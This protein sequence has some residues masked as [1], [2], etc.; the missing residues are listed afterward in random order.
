MNRNGG[1]AEYVVKCLFLIVFNVIFYMT[2]GIQN[3]LSV[4]IAYGFIH[5]AYLSVLLTP[6]FIPAGENRAVFGM[7]LFVISMAY[8]VIT[9]LMGI[10]V[11]LTRPMSVKLLLI[12]YIVL[13][14]VYLGLFLINVMA[15]Q[16]SASVKKADQMDL[17]YI[18]SAGNR[19]AYLMDLVSEQ[20]SLKRKL[21]RAYDIVK[22]SP[23]RS[24]QDAQYYE[25]RVLNL[26]EKA[27]QKIASR[28]YEEAESIAEELIKSANA[29][30]KSVIH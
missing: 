11:F 5:I 20:K 12:L 6:L 3:P 30:N 2:V 4:W 23:V 24:N 21:E 26:I 28:S 16:D 1:I 17:S 22:A 15:N 19:L 13:S 14:A 25:A 29:R 18:K 7:P 8:F 9:F 10:F 27:E